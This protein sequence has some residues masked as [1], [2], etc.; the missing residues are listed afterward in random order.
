MKNLL[1]LGT[2][3]F[4]MNLFAGNEKGNGGGVHFC[5]VQEKLELY[6]I[7]EAQARY[8]YKIMDK[9]LSIESYTQLALNKITKNNPYIGRKVKEQLDYLNDGHMIIRSKV[10]LTLV[11]D[12]NI[13][14]TDEDCTYKQL[15]NWDEKSGNLIVKKEYYDSM[16]ALNKAAFHIHETL[17]KVGRD[18]DLLER[19][20]DSNS[21]S[22]DVRRMV[23]EIFST[24]EVLNLI[25]SVE[26]PQVGLKQLKEAE[27]KAIEEARK[28]VK[29]RLDKD[30]ILNQVYEN[31][32][33][34]L[35]QIK[36]NPDFSCKWQVSSAYRKVIN[37][38][39][40][41]VNFL[42]S[43]SGIEVLNYEDYYVNSSERQMYLNKFQTNKSKLTKVENERNLY[44]DKCEE[45]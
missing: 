8:G 5:V 4:S 11:E 42:Q 9:K 10:K 25:W 17:Y 33:S 34:E 22:D 16:N 13:L 3:L 39:I 19:D 26:D 32:L 15:A 18:L 21:T 20:K 43:S 45:K 41:Y 30:V 37:S 12:A 40:I 14:V 2:L 7:Y 24:N 36:L 23:G 1:I 35:D 29:E 31:A 38:L 28:L 27:E 6:D 44:L